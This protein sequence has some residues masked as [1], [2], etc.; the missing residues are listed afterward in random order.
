MC[1]V[2]KKKG[3]LDLI[4]CAVN[5]CATMRGYVR[6]II[7]T[8]RSIHP[9]MPIIRSPYLTMWILPLFFLYRENILKYSILL[10]KTQRVPVLLIIP[11]TRIISVGRY[12]QNVKEKLAIPDQS[13]WVSIVSRYSVQFTM[14]RSGNELWP[15]K[16]VGRDDRRH[17]VDRNES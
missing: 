15:T 6:T 7:L 1:I 8:P 11:I 17:V 13:H 14:Q 9:P 12:L 2:K 5:I 4:I 16:V 3:N 10:T